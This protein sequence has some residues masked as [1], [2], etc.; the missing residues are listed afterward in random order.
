MGLK[1]Q[2]KCEQKF[3]IHCAQGIGAAGFG[4]I[5]E[6]VCVIWGFLEMQGGSLSMWAK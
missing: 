4:T 2:I 6:K 5:F 1:Y 3:H